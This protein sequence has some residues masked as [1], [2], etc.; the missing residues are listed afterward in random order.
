[1]I[2]AASHFKEL[3]TRHLRGKDD[4]GWAMAEV[5]ELA[6]LAGGFLLAGLARQGG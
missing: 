4:I 3:L 1:M 6:C 5:S 2:G